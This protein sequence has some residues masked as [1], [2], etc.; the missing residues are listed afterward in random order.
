M[1]ADQEFDVIV[2]GSG[3]GGYVCAIR[4]AQLGLKTACVE[5]SKTLGGTCLN[6]GCIP[7]KALLESSHHYHNLKHNYEDHGIQ[8]S[9]VKIDLKKML[10]RKNQVVQ[11]I[12][13]GVEF[14]LKKN[15]I[16]WIKGTACLTSSS[17][18]EVLA[19]K[20]KTAYKAQ[21]I[22]IATGSTPIEIPGM[23]FDHQVVV[24][25]TDAL[26]F[27]SVPKHLVLVGGGVVGLELG[28]VWSRLGSKVTVV[29]A[30]DHLLGDMDLQVSSAFQRICEKQGFTFHLN[31]TVKSV[32]IGKSQQAKV[33]C[34]SSNKTFTL[35]ADKVLIAVGRKPNTKGLNLDAVGVATSK[36]GQVVVQENW[37][38]STPN[39]YAIGDVTKGPMLAHKASEE[40]IALAE[41]IAGQ[42]GHVNYEAIPNIVYTWPEIASVGL[43]EEQCKAQNIP[44]ASGRFLLK[45]NGRARAMGDSDG[46]VKIIAHRE[47]D[48]LLG[49]HLLSANASEMIAEI[50]IAFEYGASAED[51][52]R[53]V[54]AHPTLAEAIK[55]AALAVDKRAIHS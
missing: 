34:T 19:D 4:C 45:A 29:E 50:A 5:S 54:H 20:N 18:I 14:L 3:P 55:E 9:N 33:T 15:K 35:E 10:S 17:S 44:Y 38:T 6:V 12:T 27:S 53:S 36:T 30:L 7:S 22:V 47:T 26:N 42:S 21:N 31:S 11:D 49:V 2:I 43:S 37:Q 52:A 16:T 8:A 51:I 24:D 46:F 13:K 40:G 39:I 28:S 32:Q 48:R 25:S 41:N 23:P 1:S